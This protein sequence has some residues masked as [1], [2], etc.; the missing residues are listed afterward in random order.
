MKNRCINSLLVLLSI[1]LPICVGFPLYAQNS[2]STAIATRDMNAFQLLISKYKNL[3]NRYT[4]CHANTCN[5]EEKAAL[6]QELHSVAKQAAFIGGG[7]LIILVSGIATYFY[8]KKQTAK[9][10][11]KPE[12]QKKEPTEQELKEREEK[13]EKEGHA[14]AQEQIKA[15]EKEVAEM[16][17]KSQ[18]QKQESEQSRIELEKQKEEHQLLIEEQR[19]KELL[20]QEKGRQEELRKQEQERK[21]EEERLQ[22]AEQIRIQQERQDLK[23]S[24]DRVNGALLF[25]ENKI[26][27]IGK[28][29]IIAT[30]KAQVQSISSTQEANQLL[31]TIKKPIRTLENHPQFPAQWQQLLNMVNEEANAIA[32]LP[33]NERVIATAKYNEWLQN[34]V[35]PAYQKFNKLEIKDA[36]NLTKDAIAAFNK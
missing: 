2:Q 4:K 31:D 25:L 19:K 10:P 23:E 5:P 8:H 7:I 21:R 29:D 22:R 32:Q 16:Q 15:I 28:S 33:E 6:Q 9:L 26:T 24:V 36:A 13:L 34:Y 1:L 17:R 20:E 12:E 3:Y 30:W 35:Q 14:K 18:Q 11:I 27:Q